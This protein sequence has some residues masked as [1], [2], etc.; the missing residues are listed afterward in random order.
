MTYGADLTTQWLIIEIVAR[1]LHS[2]PLKSHTNRQK[3]LTPLNEYSRNVKVYTFTYK[4]EYNSGRESYVGGIK[5]RQ[6]RTCT[7][8]MKNL[9]IG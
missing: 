8:P 1:I 3:D 9:C 7:L 5:V 6:Q 4:G 2:F